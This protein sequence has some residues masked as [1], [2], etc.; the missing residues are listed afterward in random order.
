MLPL[1]ALLFKDGEIRPSV[2]AIIDANFGSQHHIE[3]TIT[4]LLIAY[5]RTHRELMDLVEIMEPNYNPEGVS[6]IIHALLG[7]FFSLDNQTHQSLRK[8]LNNDGASA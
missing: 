7:E 4:D 3:M 1:S 5:E 8:L 6:I 2:E